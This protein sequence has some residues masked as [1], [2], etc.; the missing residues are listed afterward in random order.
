MVSA[1]RCSTPTRQIAFLWRFH[2]IHHSARDIDFLSNTRAHLVDR[3]VARALGFILVI[4]LGL[5]G[6]STTV[7]ALFLVLGTLWRFFIHA[8]V[9]WPFGFLE[10]AI[11][12]PFFHRWHHTGDARRDRN[13][14]AVFPFVDHLF[15][16]YQ[17]PDHWPTEYG[18]DTAMPGSPGGQL[19]EPFMP[20]PEARP[21]LAAV[22]AMSG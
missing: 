21:A 17:S 8:N 22:A 5:T 14:A 13:Y 12:T 2:S 9:C 20:W 7:P 19:L 6:D 15:G 10:H 1:Q 4:A 16:A 3:V 11:A 18:I